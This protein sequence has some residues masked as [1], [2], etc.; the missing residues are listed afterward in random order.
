VSIGTDWY[1]L[2]IANHHIN[3]LAID[4]CATVDIEDLKTSTKLNVTRRELIWEGTRSLKQSI[5]SRG[6]MNKLDAF[7]IN[8]VDGKL[9][10]KFNSPSTSPTNR[11]PD[12]TPGRYLLTYYVEPN[13]FPEVMAKFEID[14]Q[15]NRTVKIKPIA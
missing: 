7:F 13:N 8:E 10:L 11:Y 6:G 5:R 3:K 4:C 14:F 12:L 2:R 1:H 15:K 9:I